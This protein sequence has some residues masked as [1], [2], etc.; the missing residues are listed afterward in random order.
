MSDCC[1]PP[2]HKAARV[3]PACGGT[4]CLHHRRRRR[5]RRHKECPHQAAA[6]PSR[7]L[8][9]AWWQSQS[10]R[11][12]APSRAAADHW[13]MI[14]AGTA[15]CRSAHAP[16]D[17]RSSQKHRSGCSRC[18]PPCRNTVAQ[19]PP[20]ERPS[21]ETQFHRQPKRHQ[22]Q[23]ELQA[24]S[25]APV[26]TAHPQTNATCPKA[27]GSCKAAPSRLLRPTSSPSCVL[28]PRASHQ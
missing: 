10:L 18:A 14:S 16:S 27:T 5:E 8:F 3:P 13:P 22:D 9:Q 28:P 24:H 1:A 2:A 19:P 15:S 17:W 20:N 4:L 6:P 25:R 26:G 21:S 23:R 12:H 11:A 7:A